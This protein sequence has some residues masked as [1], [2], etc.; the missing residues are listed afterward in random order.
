MAIITC[1][2]VFANNE[3]NQQ[4]AEKV[5]YIHASGTISNQILNTEYQRLDKKNIPIATKQRFE[6]LSNHSNDA[7]YAQFLLPKIADFMQGKTKSEIRVY[8]KALNDKKL[9]ELLRN[10]V[11][12]RN[13]MTSHNTAYY[14]EQLEMYENAE[15]VIALYEL[16]VLENIDLNKAT[17]SQEQYNKASYFG[18]QMSEQYL[19]YIFQ[20]CDIIK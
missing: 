4:I 2:S 15:N 19:D 16:M 5:A 12:S 7:T 17:T 10:I 6:C 1:Q 8:Q 11:L 20:K 13:R 3:Q 9:I 18:K 14:A